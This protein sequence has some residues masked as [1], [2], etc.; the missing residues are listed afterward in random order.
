M[1]GKALDL[2]DA[3]DASAERIW[4][5]LQTHAPHSYFLSWG[6]IENWLAAL[7]VD[8]TP[9]LAVV[10]D[11]DQP[12]A[13]F[14]LAQ[15]RVRRNFVM[16]SNALYFNATGSPR[17]DEISI[18]HNGL[19]AAPGARRS[20]ASLL[21]LLPGE[22]DELFLPALDR[23]A[24]DD[25]GAPA[26]PL[27]RRYR[28]RVEREDAAPFVDLEAVRTVDGGYDALL[29]ASTRTQLRRTRNII[30]GV[31]IELATDPRQAMDI[32]G[33]MLRLHARRWAS[34]GL[35]GAFADPWF[36]RCHR[37]LIKS[38]L[39]HGEIQLL[40]ISSGGTTLGCLYNLV[41]RGR[42]LF[43]QCGLASFD[44]PHVK[45]GY[46]CHAAAVEY[47]ALVGHDTY[48]LLGGHAMYKQNLATGADRRVWLRIQRPLARFSI[49]DKARRWYDLLVGESPQLALRPA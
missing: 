15:R 14:F 2:V 17:H 16:Q 49:E 35:R 30:G 27:A 32:Y 45:P 42:V 23:Y 1:H 34:R 13:A 40:R 47:N 33:E 12:S 5:S 25:L 28:V 6:W 44:D 48:D 38:R 41:Y 7:P 18:E 22:W 24:F 8:E 43:Y 9:A 3:R 36:E 4:R 11:G 20:L 19:L 26:S 39:A 29:P 46:L 10:H 21:D 31:D 37:R